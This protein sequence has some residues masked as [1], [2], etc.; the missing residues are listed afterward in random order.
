MKFGIG[1]PTQHQGVYL[2][3]PF[4]GP[5]EIVAVTQ[6]AERLGFYSA[7]GLD[8][9]II[10]KSRMKVKPQWHEI[11]IS[12]SY[13]AAVTKNIRLGTGVIMLPIRD[14]MLLAQ[15]AATLDIFSN[16][17]FLLGI[18]LGGSRDEFE[19]IR[20]RDA[21][22]HRGRMLSESLEAMHLLFTQD[23]VTFKGEYHE[24]H[25]VS[26]YPKPV[27]KPFPIYISGKAP[28]TPKRVAK[29]GTGWLLSRMQ[30]K[31]VQERI[32]ELYPY[33]EEMGRD[34]SEIDIVASKGLSIGRTH[35]E[36]LERFMNSKLPGRMNAIV[37]QPG[38]VVPGEPISANP[39]VERLYQQNLI[40]T[41]DEI[42][43]QLDKVRQEGVDH[44]GIEYFAVNRFDEMMEQVQ[45]FGEEIMPE[46]S[47]D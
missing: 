45:W 4:A 10:D 43:E 38:N 16:G 33:L 42:K 40:G 11:M 39:S 29:W 34:R 35:E 8:Y 12:L 14:P 47:G 15:Q 2:P 13:L 30:I 44:C 28:D 3:S 21:K 24:F 32:E 31:A 6:L 23:D 5:D 41:P 19:A 17:R 46:F 1:I 9:R 18:G 36:A 22:A 25:N 26:L 27:Q 37:K 7:W 20:P